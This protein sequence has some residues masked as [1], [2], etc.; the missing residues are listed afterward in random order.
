[1]GESYKLED[2]GLLTDTGKESRIPPR[3]WIVWCAIF[4]GIV[5]LMVF[6]DRMDSSVQNI[7]QH[8]FEELVD[9]GRIVHATI[10]Y[11]PQHVLTEIAGKYSDK[12]NSTTIE[13]PFRTVVRLSDRLE[14]KLLSLPQFEPHQPNTILMNVFWGC[15]RSW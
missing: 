13:V 15:C 4:G 11:D 2:Q 6:K 8:R 5:L 7:S 3:T 12:L 14:E 9:E 1:M 10:N